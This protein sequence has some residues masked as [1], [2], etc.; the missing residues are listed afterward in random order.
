MQLI[1]A[2]LSD[3]F[4][5]LEI[6]LT[7]TVLYIAR[8]IVESPAYNISAYGAGAVLYNVG[9]C[10][11]NI[12]LLVVMSDFSSLKWRVLYQ[13][14]PT[15]GCVVIPW[16]SGDV[17]NSI[18][19]I[20]HWSW[21]IGFWAF[22]FPLASLPFI[23]C[24]VY[25]IYTTRKSDQWKLFNQEKPLNEAKLLTR[26]MRIFHQV[27]FIGTL[28]FSVALG[29]VLVPLT[30][31]GGYSSKWSHS[32]SIVPLVVGSVL[33]V[34]YIVWES[35]M[36]SYPALPFKLLKDR[37]IWI[38]IL[39]GFL[40]DLV[41]YFSCD[42]MYPV[43]MV[44]INES[45]KSATNIASL[46]LFVTTVASPFFAVLLRWTGRLKWYAIGGFAIWMVSLGLFFRYRCG[47]GSHDG[48]VAAVVLLGLGRTFTQFPLL[49]TMQARAPHTKMATV[50]GLFHVW[51]SVGSVVGASISGAVWTQKMPKKLLKMLGSNGLATAAYASPY[52]FII[53]YPWGTSE[54]LAVVLAYKN[55]Q[56]DTPLKSKIDNDAE[57]EMTTS[58]V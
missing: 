32:D 24:M 11:V 1:L 41:Y 15:W 50:T 7:S 2:R 49:T 40:M 19:P 29:C 20:K 58:E 47:E 18:G 23:C 13:F 3:Y 12:V 52:T 43:L 4:G 38:P 48:M 37:G 10:C 31:A 30:L 26:V 21:G 9:F 51:G 46:P 35:F 33:F 56:K 27:D 34:F 36:A 8:S 42:Y 57:I 55:V 22:S 28:I 45:T 54:R 16:I 14:A 17:V 6:F 53:S 39:A 25:M 44:A 5:R